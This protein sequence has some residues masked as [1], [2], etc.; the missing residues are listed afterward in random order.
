[1]D[2]NE[3]KEWY[4][5]P[6]KKYIEFEG[7]SRRKELWIFVG[8][9]LVISILLNVIGLDLIGTLFSLAITIPSF[10]V[11]VRRM[12]DIGRT[13]WFVLLGLIPIIGWIILIYLYTVEGDAGPNE[14][15]PD[16][17]SPEFI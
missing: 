5:V 12:H 16:P 11:G 8:V 17:K 2:F 14:Y 7:R 9:N 6:F 4:V 10:A 13:G 3:I 15:G 1:M